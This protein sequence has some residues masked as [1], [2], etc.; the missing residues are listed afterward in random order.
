[1]GVYK[2]TSSIFI[3]DNNVASL[4]LNLEVMGKHIWSETLG[5]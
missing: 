5:S 3:D 4:I 1:M 2:I